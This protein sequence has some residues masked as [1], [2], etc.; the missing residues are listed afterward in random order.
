MNEVIIDGI[1]YVPENT[2]L[3]EKSVRT[4]LKSQGYLSSSA[5]DSIMKQ[6]SRKPSPRVKASP[7]SSKSRNNHTRKFKYDKNSSTLFKI[8]GFLSDGTILYKTR[9]NPAKWNIQ[10]AIIIRK[11]MKKDSTKNM[12]YGEVLAIEDK[13][14]LTKPLIRK[15]M[16]NIEHGDLIKFIK[17]WEAKNLHEPKKVR[18]PVENNPKKRRENGWWSQ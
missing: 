5:I 17:K 13:V 4:V 3:S 7:K 2:G 18:P 1:K 15:I 16:Y 6:L 12:T 8:S 9:R 11:M 14:K 10:Q